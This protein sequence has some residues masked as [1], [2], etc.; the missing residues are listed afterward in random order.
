[1]RV[2]PMMFYILTN[3]LLILTKTNALEGIYEQK[4]IEYF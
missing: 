2:T 1:M 4:Y 3:K